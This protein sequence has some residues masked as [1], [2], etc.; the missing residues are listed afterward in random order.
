M[1][2]KKLLISSSLI[3]IFL[4]FLAIF[5]FN[6][7]S[8]QN[9]ENKNENILE[10][11]YSYNKGDNEKNV[12][13]V[14]FIDPECESCAIFNEYL[15]KVYKDYSQEIKITYKYIP[16]HKNSKFAIKILEASREQNLYNEVLD[17]MLKYLPV[18]AT[19]KNKKPELLWDILKDIP[20]ID[21]EKIRIDMNNSKIEDII[22]QDLN[23]ARKLNVRGTPTI[24][25][26]NKILPTLSFDALIN[27]VEDEIYK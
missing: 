17:S 21:L 2:N 4:L 1:K 15:K 14:E 18:W 12:S 19:H 5:S 27:A 24:F 9:D 10:R 23:D 6:Q 26:N 20:N 16:N 11:D 3:I 13:I 8:S 25:I 7:N 22:N